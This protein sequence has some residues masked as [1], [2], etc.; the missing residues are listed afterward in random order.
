MESVIGPIFLIVV[1]TLMVVF[2][3]SVFLYSRKKQMSAEDNE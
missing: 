2:A 1:L 3:V